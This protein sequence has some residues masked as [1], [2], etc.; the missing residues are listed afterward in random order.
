MAKL[1]DILERQIEI[2]GGGGRPDDA[3]VRDILDYCLGYP[4]L[5][6]HPKEDLVYRKLRAMDAGDVQDVDWLEVVGDLEA[7]HKELAELTYELQVVVENILA[8]PEA[9][10]ERFLKVVRNFL[11]RYRHHME[12]EERHLFPRA[13]HLLSAEDW[14]EIDRTFTDQKDPFITRKFDRRFE[15]FRSEI[16]KSALRLVSVL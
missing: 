11:D 9:R 12:M 3:I 6:H 14:A 4:T 1:F 2:Y 13:L 16:L 7:E 10:R 5:C 8:D 15:T